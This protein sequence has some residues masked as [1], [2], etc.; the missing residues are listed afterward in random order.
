MITD[1]GNRSPRGPGALLARALSFS[2]SDKDPYLGPKEQQGFCA[3]V[4]TVGISW[5]L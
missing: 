3:G 4:R 1:G 2:V 5:Y